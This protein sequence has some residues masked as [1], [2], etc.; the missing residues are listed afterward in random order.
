MLKQLFTTITI[1]CVSFTVYA[2]AAGNE[3]ESLFSSN[4]LFKGINFAILLF[5][6]YRF[7]RK[8]IA[9]MLSGSAEN[10]KKAVDEAKEELAKAKS[11][12][13]EYEQK[14]A[15]LEKELVS[16]EAAAMASIE[17]EKE[18][19]IADAKLQAQKLEEQAQNR[20]DQNILKTK[21]DIREF[22][23]NESVQLAEKIITEQI[24]SKEQK[25][26]VDNYVK[27]FN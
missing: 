23:V 24:G 13:V 6:L 19:M 4:M 18:K 16:R 12:L 14:T 10:T 7:V 3:T 11:Q 2:S 5:L 9:N 20:I 25:T 22:L 15:D 1:T 8:P 26:L 27:Y 21:N 17:S